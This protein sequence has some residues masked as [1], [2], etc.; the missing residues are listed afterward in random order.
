MDNRRLTIS[1]RPQAIDH[2]PSTTSQ[3]ENGLALLPGR[4]FFPRLKRVKTPYDLI[5]PSEYNTMT[6]RRVALFTGKTKKNSSHEKRVGRREHCG[7]IWVDS[8]FYH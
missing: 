7:W 5:F 1:Y 3:T 6:T 8:M 2:P 4:P